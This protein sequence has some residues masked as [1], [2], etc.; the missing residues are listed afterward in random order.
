MKNLQTPKDPRYKTYKT[1]SVGFVAPL[2]GHTKVFF[3]YSE[4]A[5]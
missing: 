3:N 4:G 5:L 2:Y 1:G